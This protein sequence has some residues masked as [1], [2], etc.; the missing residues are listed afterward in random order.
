MSDGPSHDDNL[1]GWSPAQLAQRCAAEQERYHQHLPSDDQYCLALFH[2]AMYQ[3]DELAWSLIYQQ[4]TPTLLAWLYQHR[5]AKLV[6]A[7]EK[8]DSLVNAAFGN[9]WRSTAASGAYTQRFLTLAGI[10]GYLKMCLNTA[11][12]D[13]MRRIQAHQ[14][15]ES[16]DPDPPPVDSPDHLGAQE[17]WGLIERA[18]PDR[19]ELLVARLLF[20]FDYRPREVVQLFPK[21]FPTAQEVHRLTRN[22]LDRLRRNPALVRWLETQKGRFP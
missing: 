8:P 17:L 13:E 6:L 20:K 12:I 4:F 3:R 21:D 1:D 10:L 22:V 18:L 14:H 9:F 11:V 5:Y 2:R 15:E 16:G 7:Q 19:R